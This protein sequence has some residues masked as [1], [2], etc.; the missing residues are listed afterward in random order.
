MPARRFNPAHRVKGARTDER[1]EWSD[2]ET[3]LIGRG[4]RERKGL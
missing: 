3:C 4:T 2:G 1:V